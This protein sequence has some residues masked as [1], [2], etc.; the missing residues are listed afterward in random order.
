MD[1][2]SYRH[3]SWLGDVSRAP[4]QISRSPHPLTEEL[5]GYLGVFWWPYLYRYVV[6]FT[7]LPVTE[8][9]IKYHTYE[10]PLGG[11]TCAYG[12]NFT[13]FIWSCQLKMSS[14]GWKWPDKSGVPIYTVLLHRVVFGKEVFQNN[15]QF[16]VIKTCFTGFETNCITPPLIH[17]LPEWHSGKQRLTHQT[18]WCNVSI[19]L[20]CIFTLWLYFYILT[21][22]TEHCQTQQP[23]CT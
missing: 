8:W 7:I 19:K 13:T 1:C 23:D 12:N 21:C 10:I 15:P 20:S 16:I 17:Y 2:S 18:C 3:L 22:E 11:L 14:R 9:L 5:S 4:I 6:N